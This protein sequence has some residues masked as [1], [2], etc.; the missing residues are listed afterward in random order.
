LNL[1]F[2]DCVCQIFAVAADE[3]G[4]GAADVVGGDG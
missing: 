2:R 4:A 1:S 3:V